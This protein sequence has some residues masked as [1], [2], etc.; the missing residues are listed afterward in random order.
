[1]S[2]E[3]QRQPP[4]IQVVGFRKLFT[5]YKDVQMY[6]TSGSSGTLSGFNNT[7][8]FSTLWPRGAVTLQRS[9]CAAECANWVK[10]CWH[11]T[12]TSLQKQHE[13]YPVNYRDDDR[14][15]TQARLHQDTALDKHWPQ[16]LPV[17]S[18]GEHPQHLPA[19]PHESSCV[20]SLVHLPPWKNRVWSLARSHSNICAALFASALAPAVRDN[21]WFGKDFQ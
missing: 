5:G 4:N 21:P 7:V 6:M 1:M 10:M 17:V 11:F 8:L 16:K 12:N 2:T 18:L 20:R 13:T 15:M 19:A 14:G 9:S 3:Q